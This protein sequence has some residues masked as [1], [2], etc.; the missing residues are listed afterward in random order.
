MGR[1]A[2]PAKTSD[3]V[4][5]RWWADNKYPT[6]VLKTAPVASR[7]RVVD[8]AGQIKAVFFVH[9]RM[10][11]NCARLIQ[12]KLDPQQKK[13]KHADGGEPSLFPCIIRLMLYN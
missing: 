5:A 3:L 9:D 11:R 13:G 4:C 2:R 8:D 7:L 10:E 12:S 6:K 1:R